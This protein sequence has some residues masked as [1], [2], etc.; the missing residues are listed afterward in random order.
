[1]L[2]LPPFFHPLFLTFICRVRREMKETEESQE[3][4]D[5]L[6][7]EVKMVLMDDLVDRYVLDSLPIG[8]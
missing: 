7:H 6:V 8:S 2:R 5:L 1:M 4:K 3:T